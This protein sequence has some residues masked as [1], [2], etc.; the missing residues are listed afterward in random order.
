MLFESSLETFKSRF[1]RQLGDMLSAEELGAFILVLANSLQDETTHK[2]L[3]QPLAERFQSLVNS[4]KKGELVGAPDDMA[5][6]NA[7]L[8]TGI[9]C[10]APWRQRSLGPW[11]MACNPLR[12]LRPQRAS[13]ERFVGLYQAFDNQR[14]HFDKP[15]LRPEIL[16][17]EVLDGRN[18]RLMYQK[19]PFVAFHLLILLDASKH[20]PQ[21]MSAEL[22]RLAWSLVTECALAGFAVAYNSLGA[23]ASVNHQHL[24]GF[25][26]QEKLSVE[27]R[28]WKHNG[29]NKTYPVNCIPL[30]SAKESWPLI[31]QLHDSNQPYNLLYRAGVCYL[32]TRPPGDQLHLPGWMPDAA[33]YELSGGF[34]L[35]EEQYFDRLTT[36]DIESALGCV[37]TP[38]G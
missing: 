37:A 31:Q 35:L 10:F 38:T 9:E 4:Q 19:F 11:R 8:A 22:N 12:G 24:H 5:V 23:G 7:L 28:V 30:A 14:F 33:W 34:N 6:F 2:Y 29:G 20:Y 1:T 36:L 17:E 3:A 32:L 27:D 13:G 15:F 18:L 16:S 21:F 26:A 25:V